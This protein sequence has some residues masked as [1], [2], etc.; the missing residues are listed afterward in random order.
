VWQAMVGF[1]CV[2]SRVYVL[3]FGGR[4]IG[5][6]SIGFRGSCVGLVFLLVLC[7]G[8][9]GFSGLVCGRSVRYGGCCVGIGCF[10]NVVVGVAGVRD[11]M[12]VWR[13]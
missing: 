13:P 4:L 6:R 9:I 5:D 8:W 3:L 12:M 11:I 10:L 1:D 7:F 2:G